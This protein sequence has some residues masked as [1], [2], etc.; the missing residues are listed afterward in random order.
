MRCNLGDNR[1]KI[2][3]VVIVIV[4]VFFFFF[5]GDDFNLV[6]ELILQL[7]GRL[8]SLIWELIPQMRFFLSFSFSLPSRVRRPP[9][10]P[11]PKSSSESSS[12]SSSRLNGRSKKGQCS[13]HCVPVSVWRERELGILNWG[14]K[15]QWSCDTWG[16]KDNL[17]GE[18]NKIGSGFYA[19]LLSCDT[20]WWSRGAKQDNVFFSWGDGG[21]K[22]GVGLI[23]NYSHVTRGVSLCETNFGI[24]CMA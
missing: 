4:V 13:G 18:G 22:L 10:P 19:K 14:V 2:L 1:V 15:L 11:L 24:K 12:S 16:K 9:P 17:G 20:W 6:V 8:E 23:S 3:V 5:G 7:V 21:I